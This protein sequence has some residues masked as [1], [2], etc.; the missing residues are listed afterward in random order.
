MTL[1]QKSSSVLMEP[2]STQIVSSPGGSSLRKSTVFPDFVASV[3]A[4][5]FCFSARYCF[6]RDSSPRSLRGL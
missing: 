2:P 3:T 6:T 1:A 4:S 5:N